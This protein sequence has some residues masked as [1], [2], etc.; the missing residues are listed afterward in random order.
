MGLMTQSTQP[1][2]AEQAL[3]NSTDEA[4]AAHPG[5]Q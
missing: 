1:T 2:K 4:F 5:A 3:A